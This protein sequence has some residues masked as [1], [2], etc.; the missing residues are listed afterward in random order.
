MTRT[1]VVFRVAL[2]SAIFLAGRAGGQQPIVDLSAYQADCGIVVRRAGN[3]VV[4]SW[5]TETSKG[6]LE[7][8]LRP[9]EPL[10]RTMGLA[11]DNGELERALIERAD[12]VAF[13]LV[14]TRQAPADRPPGMSVFNT[15]FDAP[16]NRPFQTYRSQLDKKRVRVASHGRRA[17][18][19]VADV[20]IGPFTGELRLTLY[21]GASLVHVETVVHTRED[22]RAILYDSG[23]VLPSASKTRFAWADTEGNLQRLEASPDAADRPLAVRHRALFVETSAGS[24][25]CFPPPHQYF[26]ARDRTENVKT[27]WFG[28]DH[29]GLESRFGFGIRQAERGGGSFVPWFNAPPGTDQRL[30]VFY[31][32]TDGDAERALK[33]TLRYTHGDRFPT[34][35]GHHTF[36]SHWH[37]ATA[38]A[39]QQ[40][41]SRGGPR[42]VPDLVPM[43]KKMGVE[44][45]HLAEFHGD[46]HPQDPG[47]VRLP[48]MTAMFDE[49]KRLSDGEILFLPGEEANV[50]LGQ[51]RQGREAGHWLYLF[52]RPVYWTMKRAP[53]QAFMEDHPVLGKVFHVGDGDEMA[54]LLDRE[55]GLAW[56]SHARIKGSSWTPDF[57]KNQAFFKS[58]HWLGAAWKAMPADLSLDKLGTRGLDL[59]DD[60]AN[61]GDKK[62]LPG[63][64]DVF[65]IDHTHEL[66]GHMNVNYLRL[67]SGRVPRFG[68]SWQPVLDSLSNGRF[69][70]TTGEVL[71]P[72]FT[73]N[74]QP[75][76]STIVTKSAQDV[77]VRAR[78]SW[79]FPLR[80]VELI[81]GD[82]TRV[83]RDRIE[84]SDTAPFGQREIRHKVDVTGRKWIRLEV[85]DVATDGAFTQPVWLAPAP[86]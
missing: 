48:E 21:A 57:F 38:M 35:D 45:V 68:E 12:P 39:A 73:V 33:E 55:E 17:T 13:L 81:S 15:F 27:A 76:G 5:P 71:I 63:E 7:V 84:L 80:F 14:G 41:K 36:T 50:A 69:F 49:C 37:M 10:F 47:P 86:R 54:Q 22:R 46:G 1:T 72:E 6:Y 26:F 85:W 83:F 16:A 74:G 58:P 52:P 42:T 23:L 8:D 18:I 79:T 62:Y 78:L 70:V 59:L 3:A 61:W 67:G 2:F 34:I 24:V 11:A 9:G 28:R 25:A 77:E 82:G 20:T 75:S 56:T 64:V 32:L 29:R 66:F 43:F 44:I 19:S 30:G 65:K 31:L 60:M 53:G 4:V 51:A 40:E